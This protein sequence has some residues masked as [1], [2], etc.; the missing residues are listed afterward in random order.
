[1]SPVYCK[2]SLQNSSFDDNFGPC[3]ARIYTTSERQRMR[4]SITYATSGPSGQRPRALKFWNLSS[5]GCFASREATT[6]AG[7]APSDARRVAVLRVDAASQ[8]LAEKVD[9]R[10]LT[11][12]PFGDP[13]NAGIYRTF[14]SSA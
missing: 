12:R 8:E 3:R 1:M 13:R 6:S 14:V 11:C 7:R 2:L 10:W 5:A 9:G 4:A